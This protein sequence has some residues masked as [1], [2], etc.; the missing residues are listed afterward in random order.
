MFLNK[1][2]TG[3]EEQR[4]HQYPSTPIYMW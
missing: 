3:F 2:H 4:A 1:I